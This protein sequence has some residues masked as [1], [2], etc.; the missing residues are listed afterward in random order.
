MPAFAQ[1]L[2]HLAREAVFA[3]ARLVRVGVDADRNVLGFVA[4]MGQLAPQQLGCVDL[5]EQAGFE[6]ETGRQAEIAVRRARKA[7]QSLKPSATLFL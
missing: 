4:G 3:L 6:V 2:E 7:R 1:H 5:G